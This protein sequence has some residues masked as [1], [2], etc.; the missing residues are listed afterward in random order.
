MRTNANRKAVHP[1][2]TLC[3]LVQLGVS[4]LL[5]GPWRHHRGVRQRCRLVDLHR[6]LWAYRCADRVPGTRL[7]VTSQPAPA[8]KPARA[9]MMMT[10]GR[11][12]STTARLA[13]SPSTRASGASCSSGRCR[14]RPSARR[15]ASLCR[16]LALVRARFGAPPCPGKKWSEQ[17]ADRKRE[18]DVWWLPDRARRA[19]PPA[20]QEAR[21]RV[22]PRI[23]SW[24]V[25]GC[26]R[27][28]RLDE[29]CEVG[30]IYY[31]RP[32]PMCHC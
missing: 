2:T 16:L 17:C 28:A 29:G 3:R 30:F 32:R 13:A 26:V 25:R 7:A 1:H 21:E 22:C 18:F 10:P 11:G 15:A 4:R 20:V 27:R 19:H 5:R 24:N 12:R 6:R 14:S 31:K 23:F 9:P 8:Q